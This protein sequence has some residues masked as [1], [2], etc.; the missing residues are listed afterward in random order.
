M[1]PLNFVTL[2]RPASLFPKK[3]SSTA[4]S[5][6]VIW[7]NEYS[8]TTPHNGAKKK[9]KRATNSGAGL[10]SVW[11]VIHLSFHTPN[12]VP[13]DGMLYVG[14]VRSYPLD[15]MINVASYH[16]FAVH[17]YSIKEITT[18]INSR[19]GMCRT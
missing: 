16:F 2:F 6:R 18:L 9:Q 3:G 15:G 19:T 13:L 17:K 11:S 7:D 12:I 5:S 8:R 14:A 10:I 1:T 4:A